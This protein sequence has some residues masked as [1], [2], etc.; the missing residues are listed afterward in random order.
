MQRLPYAICAILLPFSGMGVAQPQPPLPLRTIEL[1]G[2]TYQVEL[3]RSVLE[4]SHG[5]TERDA[6]AVHGGML[7]R[8]DPA[9]PVVFT[10]AGMHFDLD[11]LF[12]DLDGCLI[13]A[14]DHAPACNDD[15]CPSYR[16]HAPVAWV[17]EV[18]VGTR[19]RLAIDPGHCVLDVSP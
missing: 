9:V 14:V 12:F 3:A 5:L 11:M 18:P 16:S 19:A 4:K 6:L 1:A 15:D 17:L 7:F 2:M 8:F 10:M 13:S